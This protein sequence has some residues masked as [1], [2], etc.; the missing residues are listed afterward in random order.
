MLVL[1][2]SRNSSDETVGM[3]TRSVILYASTSLSIWATM[4]RFW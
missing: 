3:P 1:D 2:V 4:T